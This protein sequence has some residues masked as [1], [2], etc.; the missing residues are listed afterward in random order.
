MR[1]L[2]KTY[3]RKIVEYICK[4]KF[5]GK[6]IDSHNPFLVFHSKKIKNNITLSNVNKCRPIELFKNML[7]IH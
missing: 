7:F 5:E 6:S 4:G 1:K 3:W 2:H